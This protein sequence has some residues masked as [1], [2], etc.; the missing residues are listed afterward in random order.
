MAKVVRTELEKALIKEVRES[1]RAYM[2]EYCKSERTSQ[3][4]V[5]DVLYPVRISVKCG[6]I[7]AM[8][9]FYGS[10]YK[11]RRIGI[12][13]HAICDPLNYFGMFSKQTDDK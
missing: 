1:I 3:R 12:S 13:T 4:Y 10:T 5:F 6:L 11:L 8:I 2:L 9:E 7:L